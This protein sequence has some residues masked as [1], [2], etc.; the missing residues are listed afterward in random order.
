MGA[1]AFNAVAAAALAIFSGAFAFNSMAAAT[2]MVL[3]GAL[4][5]NAITAGAL[6]VFSGA[7]A[8]EAIAATTLTIFSGPFAFNCHCS[9]HLHGPH[10]CLSLQCQRSCRPLVCSAAGELALNCAIAATAIVVSS[11]MT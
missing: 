2:F 7:L 3:L 6:V 8:F 9:R 4:A 1:L 11:P 5:C 10:G